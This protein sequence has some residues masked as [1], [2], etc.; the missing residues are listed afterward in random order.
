M[1]DELSE[2][3]NKAHNESQTRHQAQERVRQLENELSTVREK[4]DVLQQENAKLSSMIQLLTGKVRQ[5]KRTIKKAW[6]VLYKLG[7]DVH[8]CD[9]TC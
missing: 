1:A 8:N 9:F 6:S 4:A 5:S 2:C 7:P 3:E